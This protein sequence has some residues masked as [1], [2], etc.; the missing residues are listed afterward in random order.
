MSAFGYT[1]TTWQKA[2]LISF[3]SFGFIGMVYVLC[4]H[5]MIKIKGKG[6]GEKTSISVKFRGNIQRR[7]AWEESSG[8][9]IG[10]LTCQS[11][12]GPP[13]RGSWLLAFS[14]QFV[15][16]ASLH[17]DLIRPIGMARN[18]NQSS[19][20]SKRGSGQRRSGLIQYSQS[21]LTRSPLPFCFYTQLSNSNSA[22]KDTV[23]PCQES[24]ALSCQHDCWRHVRKGVPL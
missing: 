10:F 19:N 14:L 17:F 5:M 4:D 11:N 20:W 3:I 7:W 9:L 23:S 13:L 6:D 15:I 21:S 16:R 22:I 12:P 24:K 1:G 2:Q 18:K 8:K